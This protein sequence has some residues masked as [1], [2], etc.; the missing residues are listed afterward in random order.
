M[1][2]E[3]PLNDNRKHPD[4]TDTFLFPPTEDELKKR[5]VAPRVTSEELDANI[6]CVNYI[7][8]GDALEEQGQ[9]TH[10]SHG[11]LTICVI[12]L[13]N[14]FVVTG[15]SACASPEN[16]QQDIGE[17]IAFE[18]AKKK[19]WGLMGYALKEQLMQ[20]AEPCDSF[21]VPLSKIY[22]DEG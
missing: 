19:I 21:G 20:A 18:D 4:M 6:S 14:G 12:V 13:K 11:L 16:Y 10:P 3:Y 17:R 22:K 15:E 7:N 8:V 9:P 5:A 1:E 2:T